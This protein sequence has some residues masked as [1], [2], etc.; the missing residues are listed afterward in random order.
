MDNNLE[1]RTCEH[2]PDLELFNGEDWVEYQERLYD[3][4]KNDFLI[5]Q[6]KIDEKPLV[7]RK[8]PIEY[9]KEEAF[10]HVT[11]QDYLHNG[12]R[13]PDIRRCERI[14]WVR[15]CVENYINDESSCNSCNDMKVWEKPYKMY[16]RIHILF[17]CERYLVVIERRQSYFLL[18]TAFYFEREH[19]F[20]KRIKEYYKFKQE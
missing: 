1:Y 3:I 9:G 5:T 7:I 8:H 19:E 18:I 14:R 20:Q 4:F 13:R 17:E 6:L 10:F 16:S 12:E 2:L 11:C 15:K